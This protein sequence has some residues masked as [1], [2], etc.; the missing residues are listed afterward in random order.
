MDIHCCDT[1]APVGLE[2]SVAELNRNISIYEV[3][4]VSTNANRGKACGNDE[5]SSDV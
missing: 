2:R 4:Q 5:L 1:Y 3:K